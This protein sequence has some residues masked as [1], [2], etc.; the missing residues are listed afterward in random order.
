M[1]S[2]EVAGRD[3]CAACAA[4][5]APDQRYCLACGAR[6]AGPRRDVLALLGSA[7]HPRA[8]AGGAAAAARS[9][10]AP[11]LERRRRAALPVALATL[12]ALV[13]VAGTRAPDTFAGGLMSG[14]T[15]VL[16]AVAPAAPP[17]SGA[18]ASVTPPPAE[19]SPPPSDV[20]ALPLGPTPD[21]GDT[22][23]DSGTDTTP[24][25]PSAPP[26]NHVFVV[27]LAQT[28]LAALARDR[29]TAPYL[30]GT[31][32]NKG[33]LLT[34]YQTI[35]QGELANEIALLSGQGPT[36]QT[37]ADCPTYADVTPDQLGANSQQLGDGCV[38][39]PEAGTIADELHG[40]GKTWRAY[41]EDQTAGGAPG[42]RRPALG[43]PDTLRD[44]RPGDAYATRRNPFVY[45]HSLI[46]GSD[47]AEDDA[48]LDRLAADLARGAKA[49]ALAW[50][51]PNLCHDG[52]A[53]PCAP[54]APAG[55]AAADAFLKTIVPKILASKAYA[56]GGLLV[57]TSDGAPPP[58]APA[59]PTPTPP[60]P[61]QPA[62][63]PPPTTP[64]TPAPSPPATTTPPT[65][66]ATTP[67]ET[68]AAAPPATGALVAR[69]PAAPAARATA[70]PPASAP[71]A[72]AA[73]A[74]PASPCCGLKA[75]P[76]VGA[77]AAAGAGQQLGALLISDSVAAGKVDATPANPFTL[78]RTFEDI[79]QLQPLGYAAASSAR[80]LP[81]KIVPSA[82][83]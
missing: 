74:P 55:P 34:G 77:A 79:F 81:Q 12:V 28:D 1:T 19:V 66:A 17:D 75:F 16:P 67:T 14:L 56:D 15:V 49:P 42:C 6:R 5:L 57:V 45:F 44:P 60:A 36:R 83:S 64:T 35:A 32:A 30:A 24:S 8:A 29:V 63:S 80:P 58:P 2:A 4:P 25:Q 51:A 52:R 78:L 3:A 65:P 70:A 38:F 72:H 41:V 73:A 23:T 40:A 46:D 69:A 68:A 37:L 76:N 26:I 54:G 13:V 31:L 61:A 10:P 50:I 7:Q 71:L 53:T 59:A 20:P 43:G 18:N 62:A 33:T 11:G 22:T 39:P 9:R 48:G 27:M 82:P 47:C 21:T